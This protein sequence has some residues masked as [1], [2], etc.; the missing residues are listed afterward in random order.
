MSLGDP[1][2]DLMVYE[3]SFLLVVRVY[4]DLTVMVIRINVFAERGWTWVDKMF[5]RY[6]VE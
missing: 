5:G 6:I 1:L 4:L 3:T 2:V